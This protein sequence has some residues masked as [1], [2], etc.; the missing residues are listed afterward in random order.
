MI[1]FSFC[2]HTTKCRGSRT[3]HITMENQNTATNPS[4]SL[5]F[6]CF[7]V[8]SIYSKTTERVPHDFACFSRVASRD[9]QIEILL[10]DW[11][12]T[13][14]RGIKSNKSQAESN[15]FLITGQTD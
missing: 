7:P 1:S 5:L 14:V 8:S 12:I 2:E 15:A 10:E 3:N 13:T 9:S 11:S 4:R 6:P